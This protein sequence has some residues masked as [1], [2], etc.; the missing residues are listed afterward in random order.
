MK[1]HY[2]LLDGLRGIAAL[3][4][5]AYHLFEA[6]AFAAGAPEQKMFHGFLAVDFFLLLSGFVM[7]HAY[8][9]EWDKMSVRSFF[10]RRLIR[11]H[12]MVVLGVF[13]GLIAFIF[14]DR[15]M[16]DGS[17]VSWMRLALATL[18]A[19]FLLPSPASLDVRGNTELFPLNGPHWSL[20]FEYIGSILYAI[21]LR[22]MQTKWLKLWV[23]C[24]GAALFAIGFAVDGNIAYGWSSQPLNMLGGFLR[25]S[26]AYPMGLLLSRMFNEKDRKRPAG[27]VFIYC[28][29]A[30]AAL[31]CVPSLSDAKLYFEM[32]C[33]AIA[34]PAIIWLGALG[35][36]G[37]GRGAGVMRTLGGISYP[38]YAIHYPFIYLYIGWIN[39]GTK[40]FG[41]YDWCTPVALFIIC[42]AVA[43]ISWRF[44]ETPVRNY[45]RAKCK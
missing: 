6:I 40:P 22:K 9:S 11:L 43:W 15:M 5:L 12:P 1:K 8:D 23:I 37:E 2:L 25:M 18:L 7:G 17:Q 10:R 20:F 24:A 16:W 30:L 41:P 42:V 21:C 38:L 36:T 35:G 34:F 31:L 26:F 4:V 33:V 19:L 32:F 14:Q 13:I 29:I 45:L 27:P 44:Y 28:V 39:N 3:M